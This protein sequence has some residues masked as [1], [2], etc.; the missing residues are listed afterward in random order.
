MPEIPAYSDLMLPVLRAVIELGGSGAGREIS[1]A[2][3]ASQGFGDELVAV[4]YEGRDKS[5][6]LDRLDWARSYCKLTGVLESPRR[7][8]FLVSNLGREIA[9]MPDAAASEKLKALDRDFRK[10]RPKSTKKE[11][12][13]EEEQPDI[14][15]DTVW[16]DDLLS[17]LHQLSPEAFER[18][19]MYFLRSQGM[20]LRRVGGTGDEG[21]DGIGTAPLTGVLTT[22]VAVQ[23]KRYDPSKTVG[24]ETVALFQSDATAA[25]A[26][27]GIL[28][29]TARFSEPAR[30]AALGRHPTIDLVD[31]EKLAELCMSEQIGVAQKPV[32]QDNWFD[33]FESE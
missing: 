12:S 20:E 24:R 31:G 13:G 27:R 28:V 9:A 26:E 25:G 33:R 22:T 7:N 1:S 17:R 10:N 23:A 8:L 2:V 29:T 15:E 21:I 16:R 3:I 4:T 32:V 18:F 30:K 14:E 19:V 11:D 6:L 5:V